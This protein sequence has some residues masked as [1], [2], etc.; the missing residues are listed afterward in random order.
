MG[1]QVLK[2]SDIPISMNWDYNCLVLGPEDMQVFVRDV[3]KA[4]FQQINIRISNKGALN[5]RIRNG[6]VY[7]ERLNAFGPEFDPLETFV[8]ECHKNSIKACIWME[9]FE[10]GYDEFFIRNPQFTPQGRPGQ[11]NLPGV[12]SYSHPQVR[13]YFLRRM[14]EYAEYGPDSVFACIKG[15]HVP[16][17]LPQAQRT[18]NGDI[19]YNPPVVQKYRELY[20]VDILS[21]QFD[22]REFAL[23]NGEFIVDFLAEARQT[24][25]QSPLAKIEYL[26][27]VNAKTLENLK[28]TT[29]KTLIAVAVKFGDTRLIDNILVEPTN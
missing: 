13:E 6:T 12:P 21:E 29:T 3:K 4:G 2:T 17:N 14:N 18:P 15:T 5:C 24:I 27:A 28:T 11:P 16:S 19:G 20:G 7:T 22:L 1:T 26:A 8:R 9:I 10:A 23:I 25:E